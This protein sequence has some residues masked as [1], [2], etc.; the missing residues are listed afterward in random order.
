MKIFSIVCWK[1]HLSRDY[2]HTSR[3]WT[4]SYI[5]DADWHVYCLLRELNTL[6]SPLP[7]VRS[8]SHMPAFTAR[9][10]C[11]ICIHCATHEHRGPWTQA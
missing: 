4:P 1:W 6:P 10:F 9:H 7:A 2:V 3:E 11:E 5:C 8:Q